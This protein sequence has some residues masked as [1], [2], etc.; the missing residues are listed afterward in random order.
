MDILNR[1]E[2]DTE[3]E[4]VY[5]SHLHQIRNN[6]L[7]LLLFQKNSLICHFFFP[8]KKS[9]MIHTRDTNTTRYAKQDTTFSQKTGYDSLADMLNNCPRCPK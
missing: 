7:L 6:H 4:V 3:G 8:K 2:E 5:T 9:S 1:V